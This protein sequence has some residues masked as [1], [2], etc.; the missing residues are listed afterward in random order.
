MGPGL[1]ADDRRMFQYNDELVIYDDSLMSAY[2]E[3][4]GWKEAS[5]SYSYHCIYVPD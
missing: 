4:E 2:D 5:K 1:F 3:E